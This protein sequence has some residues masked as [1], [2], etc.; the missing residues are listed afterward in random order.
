MVKCAVSSGYIYIYWFIAVL[1]HL[2][3]G[4]MGDNS[5]Q[6]KPLEKKRKNG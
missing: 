3:M 4:K 1:W 5:T 6:L 2:F